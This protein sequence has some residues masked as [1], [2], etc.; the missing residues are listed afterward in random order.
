LNE[1][2]KRDWVINHCHL[3]DGGYYLEMQMW[4][5]TGNQ[6]HAYRSVMKT[7]P[8]EQTRLVK[9]CARRWTFFISANW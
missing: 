3:I 8:K 1:F 6:N 7:L 2:D 9:A 5:I 4:K